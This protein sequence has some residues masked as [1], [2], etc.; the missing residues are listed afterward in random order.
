MS[1]KASFHYNTSLGLH[2]YVRYGA[3]IVHFKGPSPY[4]IGVAGAD[5]VIEHAR[6][7]L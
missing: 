5:A 7:L 4:L 1:C 2:L 3:T 6:D